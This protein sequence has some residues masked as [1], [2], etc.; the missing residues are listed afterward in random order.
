MILSN[1]LLAYMTPSEMSIL[2]PVRSI[3]LQP[4]G[5]S[6]TKPPFFIVSC[7][8]DQKPSPLSHHLWTDEWTHLLGELDGVRADRLVQQT[9]VGIL[10]ASFSLRHNTMTLEIKVT[11]K[12]LRNDRASCSDPVCYESEYRDDENRVDVVIFKRSP[13]IQSCHVT[14]PT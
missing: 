9:G 3:H 13:P 10:F 14:P 7:D 6:T 1:A 8:L 2:Q 12:M 4:H 5:G 11:L